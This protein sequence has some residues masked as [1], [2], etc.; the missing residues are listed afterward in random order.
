MFL[1]LLLLG[2]GVC[3]ATLLVLV[4]FAAE[5][6]LLDQIQVRVLTTQV[7]ELQ[8]AL[9]WWTMQVHHMFVLFSGSFVLI[10][11]ISDIHKCVFNCSYILFSFVYLFL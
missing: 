10:I 3:L 4:L 5:L 1:L 2:S 9:V 7:E 11:F 8:E 6:F